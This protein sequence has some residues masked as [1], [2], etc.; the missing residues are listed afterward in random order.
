MSFTGSRQHKMFGA[1]MRLYKN[2]ALENRRQGQADSA[3]EF[4]DQNSEGP[5]KFSPP[6][7]HRDH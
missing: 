7:E 3:F 4:E 2:P 5:S 6:P 1:C